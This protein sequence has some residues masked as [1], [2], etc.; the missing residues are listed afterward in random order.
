MIN[1]HQTNSLLLIFWS[2]KDLFLVTSEEPRLPPSST[3][4]FHELRVRDD[5]SHA[6]SGSTPA[7]RGKNV[8]TN[9]LWRRPLIPRRLCAA[10]RWRL[11]KQTPC[12]HSSSVITTTSALNDE[13]TK[14]FS[15]IDKF[16]RYFRGEQLAAKP[17]I[18]DL[19]LP[20]LII[21]SEES[22]GWCPV[23]FFDG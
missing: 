14:T 7:W 3:G 23:R 2:L 12:F 20:L 18:K 5:P 6:A 10:N 13:W 11:A 1:W 9:S 17:L 8:V 16:M 4:S 19:L 22:S 15:N 21:R